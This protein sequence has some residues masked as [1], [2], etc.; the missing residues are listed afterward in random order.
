MAL[1][2]VLEDIRPEALPNVLY[3]FLQCLQL[4]KGGCPLKIAG[5]RQESGCTL[6]VDGVT[7]KKIKLEK[8]VLC[9]TFSRL[10]SVCDI[11]ELTLR[12]GWPNELG[13]WI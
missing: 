6:R 9:V 12:P 13:G 11:V 7:L 2:F 4:A 3:P 10:Y 8:Y 5:I 1:N